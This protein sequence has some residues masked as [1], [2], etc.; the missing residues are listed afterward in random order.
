MPTARELAAR[1]FAAIVDLAA[2]LPAPRAPVRL[3]SLPWLDLVAPSPDDLRR[4][5]DAI[6]RSRREGD[7]LV[8]CALGYGR[9][10]CAVAAW[11]I[12]TGR[13]RDAAEALAFVRER[14]PGAAL[15]AAHGEALASLAPRTGTVAATL[16][17]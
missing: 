12:E 16:S 13:A 10:A 7:V 17:A 15:G 1:P 4:A 11:L 9:S 8:C 2:E 14:R 6:E 5:A 3:A